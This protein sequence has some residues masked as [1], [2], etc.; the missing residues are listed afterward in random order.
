MEILLADIMY[1]KKLTVRQVSILTGLPKSTISDIMIGRTIP[2]ID[3]LECIAKGL[4]I[5][6][7]DLFSS[8]FK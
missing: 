2:R 4:N 6:I 3:T 1:T 7:T 8:P 5:R